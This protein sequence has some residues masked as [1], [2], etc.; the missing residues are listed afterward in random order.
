MLAIERRGGSIFLTDRMGVRGI[1]DRLGIGR[2]HLRGEYSRGRTPSSEGIVDDSVRCHRQDA[3][4]N[5]LRLS[6][7]RPGPVG[8]REP[9]IGS[10]PYRR[11]REYVDDGEA[12]AATR[13]VKSHAIS[14]ATATVIPGDSEARK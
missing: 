9:R 2:T 5:R 4:R 11:R 7:Q 6:E 12:V 13:V 14:N 10:I 1:P 8:Q 3:F